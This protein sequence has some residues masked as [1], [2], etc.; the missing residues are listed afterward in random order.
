MT[1]ASSALSTHNSSHPSS[2]SSSRSQALKQAICVLISGSGH[3]QYPGS[4]RR[5]LCSFEMILNLAL[6]GMLRFRTSTEATRKQEIRSICTNVHRSRSNTRVKDLAIRRDNT[7]LARRKKQNV[8]SNI[9][10][11]SSMAV[12]FFSVVICSRS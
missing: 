7:D 4:G 6:D 3:I 10:S 5:F 11:N 8:I 1:E 9:T 12:N 2:S